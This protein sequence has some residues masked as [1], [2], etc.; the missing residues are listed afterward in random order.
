MQ[1]QASHIMEQCVPVVEIANSSY[2]I[3]SSEASE[4]C[5][6]AE[7]TKKLEKQLDPTPRHCAMSHLLHSLA[8]CGKRNQ[9]PSTL[10]PQYSP[11]QALCIFQLFLTLK[12][13]LKGHCLHVTEIQQNTTAG[14]TAIP[15][16]PLEV[17]PAMGLLQQ[18]HMCT[19]AD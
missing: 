17:I 5:H 1:W 4:T 18:V 15:K 9:I 13:W 2:Y 14:L 8:F 11:D 16:R 19:R 10:Q 3:W 6:L 12:I 7:K